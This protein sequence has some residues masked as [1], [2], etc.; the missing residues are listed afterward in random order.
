MKTFIFGAGASRDFF[1]PVLDTAYLTNKVCDQQEWDRV[2][3]KYQQHNG[4]NHVM[5]QSNVIVQVVNEIRIRLQYA[6]FEQIAEIMDKISSYG[7]DH[8]TMNNMLN[9][10][11]GV[12]NTGFLPQNNNPFGSEWSD[13]PF[14]LRE[15]IA[16]AILDMENNHK[17]ADYQIMSGLQKAFI[18]TVCDRDDDVS[19]MSLNYDDCVYESLFG[20]GFENGYLPVNQ[21]YLRQLDIDRFM[22]A[23]KVVYF[24]HGHLKFQFTDNDNVTFWSDSNVANNERWANINGMSVGSTLLVLPGRFS[25]NWNTFL[26]TGQTKDEGLNHLPYAVYYQRLAIDLFKSDTVY[27]V[28]YSFGDDHVNRLL[29]SFIKLNPN[30]KVYIIDFYQNQI[31]LVD[32]QHDPN[33]IITKIYLNLGADWQLFYSQNAGLMPVNQVEVNKANAQ[34]WGEIFP[35]VVFYKKGY[36]TFLGEFGNVI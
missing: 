1:N 16:E 20:L 8:L 22:H 7:Y 25:Y 29:R 10:L 9:L 5:V 3:Q 18:G 34:G 2:M 26:S 23:R 28:G 15:I 14:L 30:N 24:P 31:T 6:N 13:I 21:H 12:M 19:V 4:K 11:V 35:Q 36:R 27:V 17:V 32:E 33:N